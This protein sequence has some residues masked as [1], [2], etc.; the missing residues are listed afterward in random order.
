MSTGQLKDLNENGILPSPSKAKKS[1]K[2]GRPDSANPDL[3]KV[4]KKLSMEKKARAKKAF[5][6]SATQQTFD[7]ANS[8]DADID[9]VLTA[10]SSTANLFALS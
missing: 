5:R 10:S 7:P 9:K 3:D 4:S 8:F 1:V 6:R 2:L